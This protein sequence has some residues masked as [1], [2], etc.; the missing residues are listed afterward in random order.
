MFEIYSRNKTV[1]DF[2]DI[3]YEMYCLR[4]I[5]SIKRMGFNFFY[6]C[7]EIILDKKAS[8]FRVKILFFW[9]SRQADLR[10][11]FDSAIRRNP[12]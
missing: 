10:T 2:L 6:K 1:Q 7:L 11:A 9:Q 4:Y 12:I 3:Q 8:L 5:S